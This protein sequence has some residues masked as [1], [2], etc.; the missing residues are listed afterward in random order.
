MPVFS[1][2]AICELA[3]LSLALKSVESANAT[4]TIDF[5]GLDT[6]N[7]EHPE[8]YYAGGFG[9]LGSGPGPDYGVTF[10]PGLYTCAA[11]PVGTCGTALVPVGNPLI[12]GDGSSI[13]DVANGFTAGLVF[14]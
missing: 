8:S 10:S 14:F 6:L 12:P 2:V 4:V 3:A 11:A 5:V 7:L 1:S 9:S 13:M